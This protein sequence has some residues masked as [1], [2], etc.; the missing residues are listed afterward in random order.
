M[1]THL[2]RILSAGL[3]LLL[4]IPCS[5]SSQQIPQVAQGESV[6]MPSVDYVDPATG[7]L[8][9][10]IPLVSDTA[11]RGA[12]NFNYS[13]SYGG[14]GAWQVYC[15]PITSVCS[16]T[17]SSGIPQGPR[18]IMEG[19]LG[20]PT[21]QE[22]AVPSYVVDSAGGA[23]HALGGLTT[24]TSAGCP[25]RSTDASGILVTSSDGCTTPS[26]WT[27]T[28]KQGIQFIYHSGD[29]Q[30]IQDP[31]GNEMELTENPTTYD[32]GPDFF[33]YSHSWY[34]W[35][36]VG[37]SWTYQDTTD[38]SGCPSGVT[39]VKLWTTPGPSNV[40]SGARQFKF[41]YASVSIAT[42]LGGSGN[43]E[44]SYSA[45]FLTRIILPDGTTWQFDYNGYGDIQ[46]IHLPLGGTITYTYT[47]TDDQTISGQK[48]RTVATRTLNDGTSSPEWTY[49]INIGGS[50]SGSTTTDPDG[51]DTAYTTTASTSWPEVPLH[52]TQTQY[53]QGSAS[54]GTLLKTVSKNFNTDYYNP[55]MDGYMLLPA[56]E[57]PSF[58]SGKTSEVSMYY[59][60]LFSFYDY[61]GTGYTV[62]YGL[63]STVEYY[64]W[65]SGSPGALLSRKSTGYYFVADSNYQTA[66]LL[67]LP[68]Y[69]GVFMNG[70]WCSAD[71]F[72]YDTASAQSSGV[73]VLHGSAPNSVRGNLTQTGRWLNSGSACSGNG[74][75]ILSYQS[76]YDTWMVKQATDPLGNV[77]TYAYAVTSPNWYGSRLTS[78][79]NALSQTMNLS[80]DW[81]SGLLSASQD[82]NGNSTTYTYDSML[83]PSQVTYPNGG[84]KDV[85]FS[86]YSGFLYNQLTTKIDSSNSAND[87]TH[88]DGLGRADRL[89]KSNGQSVVYDQQDLCYGNSGNAGFVSTPYHSNTG[90]TATKVCSSTGESFTY[91][92]LG[93]VTQATKPGSN[94]VTTT[95]SDNC[96]TVADEAGKTRKSCSD[97][98]GRVTDVW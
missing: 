63:V 67:T 72:W 88:F 33:D 89:A 5:A 76:V 73:T 53:Y 68:Y 49:A 30:I 80:Y 10:S 84:E 66:N 12:L 7:R 93:R 62:P 4:L 87:Y 96:A 41:C 6:G 1:K 28:S 13:V 95:Y 59:N 37:R 69:T 16:W 54:G 81:P 17:P 20:W 46:E 60:D 51:N 21:W 34:L 42:S 19:G 22:N 24:S 64:D 3:L 26:H 32:F 58:P 15:D 71:A 91:D 9:V 92:A 48:I 74:A 23:E 40:N 75:Y 8:N 82:A 65:G 43:T 11:Q 56:G 97:A 38:T 61:A 77:T 85:A 18:P 57:T 83:R 36:T 14:T 31:N 2:M 86:F 94:T 52:V 47:T 35:D 39:N 70:N 25:W 29:D 45:T 79:T 55:F 44:Y 78:V 98:M 90:F 50:S 27:V